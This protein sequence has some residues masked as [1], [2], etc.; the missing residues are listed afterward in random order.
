MS[1]VPAVTAHDEPFAR[2]LA[3]ATEE[4]STAMFRWTAGRFTLAFEEAL[5]LPLDQVCEHFQ[6]GETLRTMA[7]LSLEGPLSGDLIV[8]F[9][10][11]KARQLA[12]SLLG[13]AVQPDRPWTPLEQSAL[14]E[15]GNIVG[16]AYFNAV[17]RLIGMELMPSPPAF[18][19][20]F[21]ASTLQQAVLSHA[22]HS[23]QVYVCKTQFCRDGQALDGSVF[24]LPSQ[25]LRQRI[26]AALNRR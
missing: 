10:D 2:L 6:L 11:V 14:T 9:D 19:E 15:T 22:L 13:Q 25:P 26:E 7:V 8:A 5:E 16:C 24:F 21:G 23:E 12:A 20:D 18:I 3:S 4:A 17:T 1:T